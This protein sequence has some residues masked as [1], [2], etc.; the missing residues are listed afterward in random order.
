M[1]TTKAKMKTYHNQL[2]S[3]NIKNNMLKVLHFI[4]KHSESNE[5]YYYN[6]ILTMKAFLKMSHQTLTSAISHLEDCGMVKIVDQKQYPEIKGSHYSVYEY[7][8]T[9]E[10]RNEL[11]EKRSAEKYKAWIKRGMDE[12]REFMPSSL[13]FELT[14]LPV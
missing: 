1:K 14:T 12:F 10:E 3:G 7:V 11:I 9:E 13:I 4:K 8:K 5:V 2:V 6:D